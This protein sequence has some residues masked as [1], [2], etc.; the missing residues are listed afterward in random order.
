[1]EIRESRI[2]LVDDD[3]DDFIMVR[4]LLLEI[5]AWKTKLDWVSNYQ[6]ALEKIKAREYDVYLFDYHLG[7]HTGL[8]LVEQAIADGCTAP[9]ILLTGLS[10]REVDLRA[11]K[12][13]A[14]D[15]LVK[16]QIDSQILERSIRYALN[17]KCIEAELERA[18]LEALEASRAKSEFLANMSHEIRTPL[19]AMIG[20]TELTFET[21]LSGEQHEYLK[22]VQSSS[23]AL[24]S[25][26][27]DILD[28]SKIETGQIERHFRQTPR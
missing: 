24:L 3:Q 22:V 12:S 17:Q 1:M 13:G 25:L 21:D 8:E 18:K 16:G 23:E 11:M 14:V 5:Q 2:L 28:F 26:T 4:D 9:I 27:N 7:K 20:M 15:Y 6:D 19:N 10:D